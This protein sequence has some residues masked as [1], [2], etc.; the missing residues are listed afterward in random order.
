MIWNKISNK[1]YLFIGFI[2]ILIFFYPVIFTEQ[3]FYFRD[4]QSIF[5][6]M[7]SFLSQT[8]KSGSIPFWCPFYYCGAPFMSDIQ[9]GVFYLPSLIFLVFS[10]PL[11]FNFYIILHVFLCV[12]FVYLFI[13]DL[14]LSVSAAI[15]SAIAYSYGGYV[16]SSINLLNNLTV[17]TW[18]PAML[19]SYQ[20]A[21]NFKTLSYYILMIFFVCLAILGGEP[22][23][24]IFSVF[25][26]WCFGLLFDAKDKKEVSSFLKHN[27]TFF[28]IITAALLITVIQWGPTFLD[29]QHSVRLKGF[30]F[31]NQ[32][33]E[34][35]LSWD[36]LKH[37]L[38]PVSFSRSLDNEQAVFFSLQGKMPWLLSI[39][40]GFLVTLL[41][42]VG[43][44]SRPLKMKIFWLVLFLTG[45]VFA[46]G[47]NTPIYSLM[48]KIFPFF[49][50][51]EKF[52]FLSNIGLVVLAGY[53]FDRLM[54]ILMKYS[55]KTKYLLFIVPLILFADLYMSHAGLNPMCQTGLYRFS[56]PSLKPMREDGERFR[57]YV[58]EE[59]FRKHSSGNI[60]IND[61]HMISQAIKAPNVGIIDKINYV[62]GRTGME[63]QYQWIITEMLKRPWPE[64]IRFLQLANAKYIISTAKLDKQPG[65]KEHVKR[66]NPVLFQI[67]NNLPRAWLVGEIHALGMWTL[68][69]FNTRSFDARTSA[70]GPEDIETRHKTPYHQEVDD[71]VYDSHNRIRIE[72]TAARRGVVVLSE[73]SYPGWRASINGKPANII[74]LNYL[75]QGI[76]VEPG[77]QQI[78]FEYQ[79]PLFRLFLFISSFTILLFITLSWF[80]RN[81]MKRIIQ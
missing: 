71:I 80:F 66:I 47:N 13:R 38:I 52:Y 64:R 22:Q 57:T 46:L 4:I 2:T 31:D 37:L 48:N 79:P 61:H 7:K 8:L 25:I 67:R 49:R 30:V 6:P 68:K 75:F 23:L 21:L 10:F 69:D 62:D 44:L 12:C 72:V 55:D 59:S 51:P 43:A 11:S 65:M 78:I 28:T 14:G 26:T 35:S 36:K 54:V 58:D 15:F 19:W 3:T 33:S 20:R 50:F 45:I 34:F 40:P 17:I 24:F 60:S 9:S 77:K 16:L 70:L 63:L 53:G 76:E 81:S 27:L 56:D 41:A 18:F 39:Y 5:Y 42:L 74:R 32:A 73:S 29:Y 1:A